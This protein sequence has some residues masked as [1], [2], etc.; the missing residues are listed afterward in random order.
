[1]R[2]FR[3]KCLV[4]DDDTLVFD[5]FQFVLGDQAEYVMLDQVRDFSRIIRNHVFDVAF[6]DLHIK[7]ESGLN[8]I[9]ELKEYS[10]ATPVVAISSTQDI[11]QAIQ[12]FRLGAF[13]FLTKPFNEDLLKLIFKKALHQKNMANSLEILTDQ[14][15]Q[16]AQ[17][18]IVGEHASM[19]K[20][21]AEIAQLKNSELDTLIIAESGCGKELVAKEL[22]RQEN[23]NGNRPYITLNCSAIPHNLMESVLFGHEKGSFTGAVQKQI[24]KFELA[25]GGDIFLDEIGTLPLE[26]QAKLLR[27]LQE[28]EIEPIGLG[29][30][31]KLNFRVI[32]ATNE[33]LVEMVK[34]GKFRKDLYFRLNKVILSIPPLRERMSDIPILIQYFQS[35]SKLG[36]KKIFSPAA[37]D[38]LAQHQWPGNVRELENVIANLFVTSKTDVIEI[39]DIA[40]LSLTHDPFAENSQVTSHV[41][42]NIANL[43]SHFTMNLEQTLDANIMALEEKLITTQ[44][45]KHKKKQTVAEILGIDRRT[46][47]RKLKQFEE[48]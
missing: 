39:D 8:L 27:T 45:K 21:K 46:L 24:G 20:L 4:V 1:M 11:Q 47:S 26:L 41:A 29:T 16:Q 3:P 33:N 15:K 18:I 17:S 38:Y 7:T 25:N 32:A 14:F 2:H 28:R 13:D 12:A 23:S 6:I 42:Q 43:P 44:L 37:L 48:K 35:K 40:K 10:P 9:K 36:H 5:Y 19:Q 30:T 22:N 31:K 34:A